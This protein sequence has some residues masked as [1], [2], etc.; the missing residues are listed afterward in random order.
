MTRPLTL[1]F[2][3]LLALPLLAA[4]M[5]GLAAAQTQPAREI[6]RESHAPDGRLE[7]R[8]QVVIDADGRDVRHGVFWR[9]HPNGRA[10]LRGHYS[11]GQP[12]GTWQW[13]TPEGHPL[14]TVRYEYGLPVVLRGQALD[15]P[16]VTFR[17]LDGRPTA[18][19]LMKQDKPHGHWAFW[20]PDGTPRADGRYVTG[21]PHGRWVFYHRDGQVARELR[22]EM[23]VLHGEFREGY[24]NGQ[25]KRAGRMEQGLKQGLWRYWH[26]NGALKAEGRY[27]GDLQDGEWRY[28]D[29]AGELQRRAAYR[30]GELLDVLEIPPELRPEPPI[31]VTEDDLAPPPQLFDEFGR[32]IER[33]P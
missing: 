15:R 9:Y 16:E 19:G 10:A 11:D 27:V 26:P 7:A 24:P 17:R 3:A 5:P 13:W 28:W 31:V 30:A 33:R 25:E 4:T 6:W 32:S 20:Y 29:E 21:I 12:D 23:G 2:L 1:L 8:W 14:R 22:Y 18:E